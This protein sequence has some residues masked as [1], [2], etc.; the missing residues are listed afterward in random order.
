MIRRLDENRDWTFGSGRG[1]YIGKL[2]GLKLRLKTQLKEWTGD[3]FFAL[4]RG[5]D[6]HLTDRRENDILT[7]IRS[8]IMANRDVL[9]ADEIMIEKKGNRV[10]KPNIDVI[11]KYSD[12]MQ[13]LSLTADGEPAPP[14]PAPMFLIKVID[15]FAKTV[16]ARAGSVVTIT[17]NEPLS[18]YEFSHWESSPQV[19][20]TYGSDE[21]SNPAYFIMPASIVTLTAIFEGSASHLLTQD[22]RRLITQDGRY[23]IAQDNE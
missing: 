18:G 14:P 21:N 2:E 12:N 1:N 3:C 16:A 5:L 8:T 6:W 22:G 20:F 17:A 4:D 19:V 11:S 7:Q 15:G 23:I 13:P 9:A 10:W